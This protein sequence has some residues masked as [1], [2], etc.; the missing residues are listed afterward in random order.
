[1]LCT[2]LFLPAPFSSFL[3]ETALLLALWLDHLLDFVCPAL[4]AR[5]IESTFPP[6]CSSSAA[7]GVAHCP[8]LLGRATDHA[9]SGT[10]VLRVRSSPDTP[11]CAELFSNCKNTALGSL[12][13]G[14]HRA[15]PP[16]QASPPCTYYH[17]PSSPLDAA[18]FFWRCFVCVSW[19]VCSRAPSCAWQAPAQRA[20][21]LFVC[22]C[23]CCLVD[24]QRATTEG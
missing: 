11:F 14:V 24:K 22:V 13:C 20:C 5:A 19:C 16:H 1:M 12:V 2:P 15:S 7:V 21:M 23:V 9:P 17:I 3:R 8:L 18:C 10:R 4:D 6:P